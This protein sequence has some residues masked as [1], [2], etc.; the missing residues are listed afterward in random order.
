MQIV[1]L[2]NNLYEILK[3]IFWKNKKTI[4]T[5]LFFLRMLSDFF[6]WML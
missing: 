1:S 5:E 3:P 2:G 6:V 4:P